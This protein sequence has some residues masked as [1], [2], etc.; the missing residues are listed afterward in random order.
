MFRRALLAAIVL[1]AGCA[2]PV[3]Q[4]DAPP[5]G[6]GSDDIG[7]EAGY[8]YDDPI[9]V[10]QSDGLNESERA[11][12]VAR[13]M[14]RVERIRG[15]EF[16]EPVP[17]EVI[18][19]AEYRNRSGGTTPEYTAWNDQVWEA[20]LLVGEEGNVSDV[21]DELY[22][23]SVLG[24]YS[25]SSDRIV[26]VSDAPRPVIDRRTLAHELLHALQDQ[27]FGLPP[28][29]RTQDAQLARN[30]LVEGDARYVERRYERRCGREWDC[31]DR[32]PSGGGASVGDDLGVYLTV[33]QPYSDGPALVHAARER[34][35]WAAVDAMYER[36]PESTE[37]VIH[38]TAYP[39]ESP[40]TV[41]VADRSSDGW[42]RYD[43]DPRADTVGE[44][45]LYAMLRTNGAIPRGHLTDDPGPRSAY[46]YSHPRTDG[47]AG[48]S[49]VPY[50]RDDGAGGYVFRSR[51]DSASDARQF[52]AAYRRALTDG[53]N[54][55]SRGD[56]VYVVEEG[57]FADAFRVSRRGAAVTVVN[58]PSRE[59][60]D[61]IHPRG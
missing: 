26:V 50:R 46:N 39:V 42:S 33:Y 56:G 48:D 44:A 57:P 24:Y 32:P 31:V 53:L 38:P 59:S 17:V 11:A 41:R 8:R 25:P 21:F 36:P 22:G 51:W 4:P 19:R 61:R 2:A 27:Q 60:L 7:R 34:G 58:G 29:G 15:R 37:Q 52:A 54:A 28:A 49:V 47:W 45:S 23:G 9:D 5:G 12:F 14:A 6:D 18:S 1:F 20:L 43:R 3:A 16:V 10:D 13:T 30:G 35:G 55:T 40:V